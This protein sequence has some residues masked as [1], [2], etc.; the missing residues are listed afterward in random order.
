MKRKG[1]PYGTG[2]SVGVLT[3]VVAWFCCISAIVL[4]LLGAG[5]A[6]AY[7]AMLQMEYHWWLVALAFIFMDAAIYFMIKQYHG[8]CTVKTLSR[9]I[10]EVI[11][12][13]LVAVFAYFLLQAIFPPLLEL[14]MQQGNWTMPM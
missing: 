12:V 9:N 13:V 5:T 4:G 3:A 14:S 10:N 2:A 11:F 8:S 7:F 1:N 6:A